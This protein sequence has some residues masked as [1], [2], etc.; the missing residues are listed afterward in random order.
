VALAAGIVPGVD[1]YIVV[2]S[3][4]PEVF[5]VGITPVAGSMLVSPSWLTS[6]RIVP[7]AGL[8][9]ISGVESGSAAPLVGGPPGAELHTMFEGL[10]SGAVGET[11]PVVLA[12][13]D[14]GMVPNAAAPG[15]SAFGDIVIGAAPPGVKVFSTVGVDG[16]GIAGGVAAGE[17][18]GSVSVGAARAN[19][20]GTGIVVPGTVDKKDVAGCADRLSS[21]GGVT[22][23]VA[24][25]GLI[26]GVADIVGVADVDVAVPAANVD[27]TCTTGVPGVICPEGV[28]QVTTVPGVLG[29]DVSGTGASVVSGAPGW[30]VTENGLGPF[31]GEV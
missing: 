5:G 14:V 29:S 9:G 11:V 28:A 10:P 17:F 7:G 13:I 18:V 6:C 15:I 20:G 26:G 23:P 21:A 2:P 16:A 25:A 27:V 12:T 22:L 1:I 8:A 3:A 24:E 31:S 30:V 19:V 4:Q